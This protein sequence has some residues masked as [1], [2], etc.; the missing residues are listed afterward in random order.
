[1]GK[2]H[3]EK[4]TQ[5]KAAEEYIVHVMQGILFYVPR[6]IGQGSLVGCDGGSHIE[7]W[8]SSISISTVNC[9]PWFSCQTGVAP[10]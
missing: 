3:R 2:Y 7:L 9:F 8:N 10:W 1:M 4:E 5:D 6:M